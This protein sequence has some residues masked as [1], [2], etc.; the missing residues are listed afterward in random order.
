MI[1]IPDAAFL[2]V[3]V[4]LACFYVLMFALGWQKGILRAVINL[5]GTLASVWIAWLL[6]P[7]LSDFVHLLPRSAAAM[8]NTAIANAAY[9]FSNE[10]IWFL[11]VF[12][13][14]KIIFALLENIAKGI[15]RIPGIHMISSILGALFQTGA[16][17]IWT[18]VFCVILS[19]P[20]F[21]NGNAVIQGTLIGTV[22]NKVSEVAGP[23]IEPFTRTD[24][25]L[26]LFQD[27]NGLQSQQRETI[28]KWLQ[29]HN[30]DSSQIDEA[31]P[32]A[33]TGSEGNS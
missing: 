31:A 6:A 12:A 19:L 27:A 16:A 4:V 5:A 1:T 17:I 28:R 23:Y 13:A 30:Y 10:L 9:Q 18:L 20:L 22:E 11:I 21:A 24:A 3:D 14:L 32:T 29:E 2:I 15:Q 25:F 26:E 8:Q 33:S 7:I